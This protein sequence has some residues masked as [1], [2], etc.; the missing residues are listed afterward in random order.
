M[1]RGTEALTQLSRPPPVPSPPSYEDGDVGADSLP[2][3]TVMFTE[4]L[5]LLPP[6]PVLERKDE[7]PSPSLD[8]ALETLPELVSTTEPCHLVRFVLKARS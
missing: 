7:L 3:P 5:P 4:S 2:L 8:G 1:A 6:P